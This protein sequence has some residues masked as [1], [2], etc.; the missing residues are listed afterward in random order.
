MT[1]FTYSDILVDLEC[2]L[3]ALRATKP[4]DRSERDR[5]WAI[6]ITDLEKVYAYFKTFCAPKEE[7]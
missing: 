5:Y 7:A 4:G 3:A 2:T 1:D 6:V